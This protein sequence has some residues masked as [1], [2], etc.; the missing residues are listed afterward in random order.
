VYLR[1]NVCVDIIEELLSLN[2]PVRQLS[3]AEIIIS[4]E[5]QVASSDERLKRVNA[6]DDP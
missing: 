6:S 1:V 2:I 4:V 5:K 3:N